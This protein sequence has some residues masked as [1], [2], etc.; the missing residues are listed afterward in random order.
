[1]CDLNGAY[2]IF[3]VSDNNKCELIDVKLIKF[4]RE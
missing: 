1:M 2:K 4:S 3:I